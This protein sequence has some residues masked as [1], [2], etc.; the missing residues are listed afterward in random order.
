METVQTSPWQRW[1]AYTECYALYALLIA[2]SVAVFLIWRLAIPAMVVAT[3][4]STNADQFIH[5]V[6]VVIVGLLLFVL[7][8]FGEPYLRTSIPRHQLLRHFA[9]L[10]LPLALAGLIGWGLLRIALA[11]AVGG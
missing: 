10:A 1:L 7:L 2:G 5:D 4:G 8:M 9:T 6:A 3:L 11:A